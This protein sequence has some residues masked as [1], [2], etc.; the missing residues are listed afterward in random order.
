MIA[1]IIKV[2]LRYFKK[3]KGFSFINIAGLTLGLTAC[4]LI[5]LF[6]IDEKK[7]DKFIPGGDRI[8]RL[9]LNRNVAETKDNSAG[10]PPMFATSLLQNFPEVENAVRIFNIQSKVLFEVADKKIYEQG[11]IAPDPSFFDMFPLKFIYESSAKVLNEPKSIVLSKE[12]AGRF[13]GN[14]N[15]V[16]KQILFDKTPLLVKGVYEN[17]PAF[18]LKLNYVV[19]FEL[20]GIPKERM[21]SW[22]WQQFYTYVKLKEG[23]NAGAV[24]K[25]FG[26]Y[27]VE[28]SRP[29]LQGGGMTYT[30]YFQPLN[31]V[32]LYSSDFKFDLIT[33]HGNIVYVNALSI[34][35][36]FILLIACF[37]F[38]NLATAKSLQRAKEVG[39][40]KSI[41]A[42]RQQ[43][44]YNHTFF[45]QCCSCS[46]PYLFIPAFFKPLY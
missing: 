13:F 40:R 3:R 28:Q 2:A 23:T 15:P 29:Q 10:T 5:A 34:I 44:M 26:Q 33:V 32:H 19:P 39:V 21:Q 38:V 18:H 16:G 9:Y 1:N 46:R 31:K 7:F 35:A 30:S 36:F 45:Y 25:K 24:E 17:N 12:M 43:L 27:A 11:G 6:V 20:M 41:G 4:I 8:Y 14:D 42:S 37:N 22:G